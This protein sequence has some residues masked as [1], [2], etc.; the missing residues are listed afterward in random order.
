[1][2]DGQHEQPL[3]SSFTN[4]LYSTSNHF[5][6]MSENRHASR[7]ACTRV[8][9]ALL[10]ILVTISPERKRTPERKRIKDMEFLEFKDC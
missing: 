10:D 6:E 3:A 7:E 2:I 4:L 8:N 5:S 1:M 9:Q